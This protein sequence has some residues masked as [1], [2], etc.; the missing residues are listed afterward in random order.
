MLNP[1]WHVHNGNPPNEK[2]VMPF[3]MLLNLVET[4]NAENKETLWKFVCRFHNEINPKNLKI[5]DSL[6]DRAIKYFKD[7]LEPSKVYKK[8]N[9]KEKSS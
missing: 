4:S 3:S 5:F 8:P 2:I 7:K 1:V 9:L 6:I